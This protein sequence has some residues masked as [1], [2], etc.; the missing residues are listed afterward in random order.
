MTMVSD[1]SPVSAQYANDTEC[2][3]WV[4]AEGS[5]RL[6]I[7]FTRVDIEDTYDTVTVRACAMIWVW[8]FSVR[9]RMA[10]EI[11][12]RCLMEAVYWTPC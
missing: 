10:H 1:G 6:R 11:L 4:Q 9:V 5:Q 12:L 3:W 7:D 2:Y 8:S